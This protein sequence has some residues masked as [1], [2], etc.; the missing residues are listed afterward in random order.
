MNNP[1]GHARKDTFEDVPHWQGGDMNDFLGYTPMETEQHIYER[2]VNEMMTNNNDR[3]R[4]SFSDPLH[5]GSSSQGHRGSQ[6]YEPQHYQEEIA[7]HEMHHG[8]QES[9][10]SNFA[11]FSAQETDY[12]TQIEYLKNIIN[13]KDQIIDALTQ[14]NMKL[15][16]QITRLRRH[17]IH[18]M[19]N[20]RSQ[21][22]DNNTSNNNN[23]N[24]NNS[25]NED[26]DTAKLDT[27]YSNSNKS[28]S[29]SSN[30]FDNEE[31]EKTIDELNKQFG[32]DAPTPGSISKQIKKSF[33]KHSGSAFLSSNSSVEEHFEN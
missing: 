21:L 10:F 11:G 2:Q 27:I 31:I 18:E 1:T 9:W 19:E 20:L 26:G 7:E 33:R 13:E 23:N 22:T 14:E 30:I 8:K 28:K 16:E 24:G 6:E 17:S 25:K 32:T 12:N 29:N 5:Q 3:A 4:G 15:K